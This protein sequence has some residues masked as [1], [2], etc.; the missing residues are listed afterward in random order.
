MHRWNGSL[1]NK[2][3]VMVFTYKSWDFLRIRIYFTK[4]IHFPKQLYRL[5]QTWN[6][7][8]FPKF[9]TIP[10][11]LSLSLQFLFFHRVPFAEVYRETNSIFDPHNEFFIAFCMYGTSFRSDLR[12]NFSRRFWV[13]VLANQEL[14][15]RNI[16]SFLAGRAR[17]EALRERNQLAP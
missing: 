7:I 6:L 16:N 3:G 9:P 1:I 15:A 11:C 8:G 14:G 17:N 5:I 12:L 2:S 13:G 4:I 10:H